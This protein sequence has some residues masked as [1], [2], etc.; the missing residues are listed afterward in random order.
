[1][2]KGP[3]KWQAAILVVLEKQEWVFLRDLLPDGYKHAEYSALQRAANKLFQYGKIDFDSKHH[4]SGKWYLVVKR[5]PP[6]SG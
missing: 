2:S 3:G 6:A 4:A 1:M 5:I